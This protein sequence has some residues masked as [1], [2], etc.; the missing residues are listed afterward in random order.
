MDKPIDFVRIVGGD[1]LALVGI[2]TAATCLGLLIN[3]FRDDRLPLIYESK[4]QRIEKAVAKIAVESPVDS[5]SDLMLPPDIPV[6]QMKTFSEERSVL[7][8][9]A[10]PEIFH[11][12]GHI[13]GAVSF[14]RE[15]FENAYSAL[16]QKIEADKSQPLA[17]YCSGASCED[18]ELVVK[19]LSSLGYTNIGMFRGGWAE[20]QRTGL[21]EETNE[22]H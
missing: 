21:P 1:L 3:Q 2:G 10:R 15:D 5:N 9:D 12:L 20:W 18:S 11:R 4:T 14:P 22:S 17:V 16:R 8:L 13:P 6:G 19:G 7:I